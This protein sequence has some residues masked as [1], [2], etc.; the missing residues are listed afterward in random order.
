MAFDNERDQSVQMAEDRQQNGGHE[1]LPPAD[2]QELAQES[3]GGV[4]RQEY[5][6]VGQERDALLDRLARLQAEF[7][8]Y[9][10]RNAREQ[11]E[12]REYA[13]ADAVKNFLPILD[14]FDLALRSQK[15]ESTDPA[16]RSGIELIRKQMDDVLSRLGVQAIP[17]Q[18]STFDPRV[19]EA[20]EM[21]ESP[22]HGD[23][24]VID[25]LQRGYKLKE[26]LLRPAMV[27]VA[28]NPTSK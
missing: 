27:R 20:I 17:A 14:N 24:E 18:G 25:E 28:T 19:H 2:A 23:H 21:V 22:D 1:S 7:E 12:F 3:Q 26:R 11:A 5:D 10:K 9:R 8:N 16:L 4:S 13:V 6:R 15:T